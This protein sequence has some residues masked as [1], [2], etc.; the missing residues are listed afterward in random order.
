[1]LVMTWPHTKSHCPEDRQ[2]YWNIRNDITIVDNLLLYRDRIII[3]NGLRKDIL[4]KIHQGHLGIDRCKKRARQSV[5]WPGLNNQI[6]QLIINCDTCI[7][8]QSS[9]PK[10]PMLI[11]D[12]PQEPC[13]QVGSDLFQY[14]N[15]DYLINV[16]YYSLWPEIYLLEE[17]KSSNVIEAFKDTFSRHGI[18]EKVRSGNGPQYSSLNF[19]NSLNPGILIM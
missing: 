5:F 9:K 11:K 7:Q 19:E 2:A 14:S 1:M 15:R 16:D 4:N 10:E 3:P 12:L 18:Q 8:Y 6:E 13:K 17:A